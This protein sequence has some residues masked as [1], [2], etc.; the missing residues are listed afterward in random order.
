M[1]VALTQNH[2]QQWTTII[3]SLVGQAVGYACYGFA[4]YRLWKGD[5]SYG[6]M[7][8]F[9]S[10][11]GSLRGS[12]S[13]IISLMPTVIRAGIS[14]E[15]IMEVMRLP[16]DSME[17]KRRGGFIIRRSREEGITLKMEHV[18]FA[19]EGNQWIYKM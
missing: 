4:A 8:M 16:R 12:F 2:F 5:I 3:T 11:A 18:D 1:V 10:M 7:T 9:V 17:T 6:T 14:A 19:Y 13:G 15:R